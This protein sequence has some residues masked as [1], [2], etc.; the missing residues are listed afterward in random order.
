MPA[1][2]GL[3]PLGARLSSPASI[4]RTSLQGAARFPERY[5]GQTRAS[6]PGFPVLALRSTHGLPI[7]WRTKRWCRTPHSVPAENANI[8]AQ[9]RKNSRQRW[10]ARAG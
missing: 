7:Q 6:A 5:A 2:L 10:M 4:P 1:G 8:S 9:P 3:V